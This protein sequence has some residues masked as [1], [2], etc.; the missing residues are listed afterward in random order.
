M[1]FE[2]SAAAPLL[3]ILMLLSGLAEEPPEV[4]L[5]PTHAWVAVGDGRSLPVR[6]WRATRQS[7]RQPARQSEPAGPVLLALH[8][9]NDTA[10]MLDA[11]ATHLAA[12][13]ITTYAYDQ[14]GF[15]HHANRGS[16]A[17]ADTLARDL[18]N[19]VV[20]LRLRHPAAPLYVLGESMG[21]AVAVVAASAAGGD[22]LSAVDGLILVAPAVWARATMPVYQRLLLRL[23]SGAV[24]F[25]KLR[26]SGLGRVSTDNDAARAARRRDP[27]I[28]RQTSVAAMLGLVGLMDAAHRLAASVDLPVL[29]L[30][31]T[32]D[33]LVPPSAVDVFWQRLQGS[34]APRQLA[35]YEHGW[36]ELLRD[37]AAGVVVD[38]IVAWMQT[39]KASLPSGAGVNA[40]ARLRADGPL[41]PLRSPRAGGGA[42]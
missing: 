31:G 37:N 3:S 39:P 18:G 17:G 22:Y 20:E 13:G 10:S 38:D 42:P 23:V 2:L 6:A 26:G 28:V 40:H 34:E 36:H 41:L 35:V 25:A 7:A 14:S 29:L 30:Y 21:A 24:P 4:R 33:E 27:L 16:W 15:G 8:G 12:S 32:R 5:P 9:M 19:L 11:P 1:T